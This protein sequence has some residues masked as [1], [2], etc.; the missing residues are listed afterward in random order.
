[1]FFATEQP[2]LVSSG[3]S[4]KKS[5]RLAEKFHEP[6]LRL[7][8]I[9]LF[10]AEAWLCPGLDSDFLLIGVIGDQH[11]RDGS[12]FGVGFN[13]LNDVETIAIVDIEL[14][15]DEN[16]IERLAIQRGEG[17]GSVVNLGNVGAKRC[18]EHPTDGSMVGDA[19]ADV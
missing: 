9:K 10:F 11:A 19:I 14:A 7:L 8:R 13:S 18:F 3:E 2:I 12:E 4:T 16:E 15:V 5:R 1:M 17:A 6:R